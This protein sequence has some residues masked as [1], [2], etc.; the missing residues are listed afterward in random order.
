[1]SAK[2]FM[3]LVIV[4]L[5]L[6]GGGAIVIYKYL[7]SDFT[8]IGRQMTSASG[9][10]TVSVPY[11][12]QKTDV[13]SERGILAAQ[14]GD[15]DM[16]MQISL[17]ADAS[18]ES[19]T[20]EHVK[21]YISAIAQ[22]SDNSATQVTVVSPKQRKINGHQGYYFELETVSEDMEIHLWSFCY[23]SASGYV[24]IDVSA[25]RNETENDADIAVG[26][27]ESLQQR[28]RS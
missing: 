3:L 2:Q 17:D 10:Y 1:M 16:Y 21:D 20:E 13:S 19:S 26:I 6:L 28:N 23:S 14:S 4:L 11:S 5:L 27:I 7:D 25:P 9:N 18:G 8:Q 12:W 24:H 22:K 15:H